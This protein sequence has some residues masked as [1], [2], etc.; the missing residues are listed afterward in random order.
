MVFAPPPGVGLGVKL[1]GG[2]GVDIRTMEQDVTLNASKSSSVIVGAMAIARDVFMHR[3]IPCT[4][5]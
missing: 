5:T 3:A 4:P 1:A 2:V